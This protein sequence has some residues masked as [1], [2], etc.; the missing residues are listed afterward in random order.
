MASTNTPALSRLSAT[1]GGLVLLMLLQLGM[2]IGILSSGNGL[3]DAHGGIGYLIFLVCA[4]AA[5][6]A[7]QLS[8]ADASAKG[9]F[10]HALSLPVLAI[11]QIGLAEMD[12][13]KWVHVVLGI[14]L[15]VDAL[16]LFMMT[17]KRSGATV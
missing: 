4:V 2:G 1:A 6:F 9:V 7:W 16:G 8:K 10:F 5:F 14:A 17:R 13:M 15:L 12:G 3:R 11:L